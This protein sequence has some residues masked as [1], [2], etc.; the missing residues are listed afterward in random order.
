VNDI[1]PG[2]PTWIIDLTNPARGSDIVEAHRNQL[3][4]EMFPARTLPAGANNILKLED[5]NFDMPALYVNG[6][7]A[8]RG[9]IRD[10]LHSDLKVVAYP[11]IFELFEKWTTLGALAQ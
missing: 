5:R 6:W 7:P 9:A 2:A 8:E 11:Y 4:A 3:L 10:W 1:H